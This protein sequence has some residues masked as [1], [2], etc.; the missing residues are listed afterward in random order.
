MVAGCVVAPFNPPTAAG[1]IAT[2][3]STVVHAS[4]DAVD[5]MEKWEKE[6]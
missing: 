6:T 3:V 1:L 5:N 4:A 2:G